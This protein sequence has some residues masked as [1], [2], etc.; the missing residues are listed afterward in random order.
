MMD[1]KKLDIM[2]RMLAHSQKIMEMNEKMKAAI[3]ALQN[4][5]EF[6][7]CEEVEQEIDAFHEND[8]SKKL[9]AEALEHAQEVIDSSDTPEPMKGAFKK[10][11]GLKEKEEK[12]GIA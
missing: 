12:I 1:E 6:K 3:D 10:L 4:T 2:K 11:T 8:E 7:K 5:A 9:H